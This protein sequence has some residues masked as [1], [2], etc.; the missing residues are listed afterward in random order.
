MLD[1]ATREG[2][3][4]QPTVLVVEA[5]DGAP[6]FFVLAG[7]ARFGSLGGRRISATVPV[8]LAGHVATLRAWAHDASNRLIRSDPQ[9][10]EF[11]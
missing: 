1:L 3:P 8:G 11:R 2:A 6:T 7:L 10:V 4:G 9:D 5:V